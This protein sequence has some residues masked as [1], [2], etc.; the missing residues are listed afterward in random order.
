[1]NLTLRPQLKGPL[2][3]GPHPRAAAPKLSYG[4]I[5]LERVA[6][7]QALASGPP[8]AST[9]PQD[10]EQLRQSYG[11]IMYETLVPD[12]INNNNKA[13]KSI[14]LSAPHI[15]DRGI[16]FVDQVRR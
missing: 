7:L 3:R 4:P 15:R 13:N 14:V 16:V 12:S 9:Y 6:D 8:V 11:Y 1:M 5:L 2:P 10:F